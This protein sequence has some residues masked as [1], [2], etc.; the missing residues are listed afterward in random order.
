MK[1]PLLF[2]LYHLFVVPIGGVQ[3]LVRDPMTRRF[4]RSAATYWVTSQ[5]GR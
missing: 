2:L 1:K 4:D 5:G 3:R